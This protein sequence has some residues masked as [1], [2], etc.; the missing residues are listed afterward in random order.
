MSRGAVIVVLVLS[1]VAL[2]LGACPG[3]A[4][5]PSFTLYTLDGYNAQDETMGNMSGG[6]FQVYTTWTGYLPPGSNAKYGYPTGM[7]F[8]TFCVET[9]EYLY[10]GT[11]YT[12]DPD[13]FVDP[14]G[15]VAYL[16]SQ[17]YKGTLSGY[18][19]TGTTGGVGD[20]SNGRSQDAKQLQRM[21]WQ[22]M[23]LGTW[24]YSGKYQGWYDNALANIHQDPA[25]TQI[26][27]LKRT[28]N[29]A[30]DLL[31]LVPNGHMVP[32]PEPGS[33]ALLATGA[34]GALPLLRRRRR[35]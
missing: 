23:G 33:L 6:E 5:V 9:T 21:I 15:A 18:D 34:L 22:F 27:K 31:V 17:W 8:P 19:Y 3:M 7:D 20:Q 16:H 13:E 12:V 10:H 11:D 28:G 29:P 26:M 24:S 35:T 4:D 14:N 1:A 30:Q 25:G 32:I 2:A